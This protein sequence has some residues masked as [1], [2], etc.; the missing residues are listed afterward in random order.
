MSIHYEPHYGDWLVG[1]N[2]SLRK[3]LEEIEQLGLFEELKEIYIEGMGKQFPG[4]SVWVD[5]FTT[6]EYWD[7][8]EA[9]SFNHDVQPWVMKE[10]KKLL[11]KYTKGIFVILFQ[12][13]FHGEELADPECLVF[14]DY[15]KARQAYMD[16]MCTVRT[17]D[18]YATCSNTFEEG[19]VTVYE[20]MAPQTVAEV[21]TNYVV[22]MCDI[23]PAEKKFL[24][25][26]TWYKFADYQNYHINIRL[27]R[28]QLNRTLEEEGIIE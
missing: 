21:P 18:S 14:D 22:E 4:T 6:P 3:K 8:T 19:D 20:E 28:I 15:Y 9:A 24:A 26:W 16:W 1:V 23:N 5:M 13:V 11:Q 27:Q 2:P 17:H 25:R 12:G 10:A 7:R